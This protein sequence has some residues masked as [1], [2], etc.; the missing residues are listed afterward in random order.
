[1]SGDDVV[2]IHRGSDG[3]NNICEDVYLGLGCH[4]ATF[5]EIR[6]T[7]R[8]AKELLTPVIVLESSFSDTST[9]PAMREQRK[10]L[11]AEAR[12]ELRAARLEEVEERHRSQADEAIRRSR[13]F[14]DMVEYDD[15]LA[16]LDAGTLM[17]IYADLQAFGTLTEDQEHTLGVRAATLTKVR[18]KKK[19]AISDESDLPPVTEAKV[20]PVSVLVPKAVDLEADEPVSDFQPGQ[21]G[22]TVKIPN[23][24][25]AI[26]VS[27]PVQETSTTKTSEPS[28]QSSRKSQPRLPTPLVSSTAN[29]LP[30]TT[31]QSTQTHPQ[32]PTPATVKKLTRNQRKAVN[33]SIRDL[34]AR[35]L[36]ARSLLAK[37]TSPES[38]SLP[39]SSQQQPSS[40][41]LVPTSTQQPAQ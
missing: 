16:D 12:A 4:R 36:E 21:E 6:E 40:Q 5:K 28:S 2:G 32:F 8:K 39:V 23:S 22:S 3:V 38:Q 34:E 18:G 17:S 11:N 24:M 33:S 19:K 29:I 13:I 35:L 1:M 37:D 20:S 26:S 27:Q 14:R 10:M 25:L 7:Y 15:D 30:V 31:L 9:T 41:P